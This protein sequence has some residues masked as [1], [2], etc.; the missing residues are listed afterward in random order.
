[1]SRGKR[2]P[3]FK[4]QLLS[5][6]CLLLWECCGFGVTEQE[7][8]ETLTETETKWGGKRGDG[9]KKRVRAAETKR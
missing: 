3:L 8:S 4:P 5:H 7:F 2:K 9:R 6:K 1:M